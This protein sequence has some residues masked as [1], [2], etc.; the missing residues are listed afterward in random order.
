M[1]L[2]GGEHGLI[3]NATNVCTNP[4]VA[5][6]KFI[7]Q[8]NAVEAQRIKLEA[9]LRRQEE[10]CQESQGRQVMSARNRPRQSRVPAG[11]RRRAGWRR[12]WSWR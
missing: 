9:K 1:T 3:A 11:D 4:Q 6:A 10:R 5:T 12:C 2:R 8:D 7:G